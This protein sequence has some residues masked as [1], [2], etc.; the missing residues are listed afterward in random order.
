MWIDQMQA[1]ACRTLNGLEVVGSQG[2][3]S[4]PSLENEASFRTGED[5]LAH[6]GIGGIL[7][8]RALIQDNS[9]NCVLSAM[10]HKHR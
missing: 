10:R 8:R 9:R 7:S 3:L 5:E 1:L 6:F 2:A 4:D